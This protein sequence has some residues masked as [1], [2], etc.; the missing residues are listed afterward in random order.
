MNQANLLGIRMEAVRLGIH[1]YPSGGLERLQVSGQFGF[2]IDHSKI[3]EAWRGPKLFRSYTLA[4][5]EPN[6]DET[7]IRVNLA[8][9]GERV[10][11]GGVH[12]FMFGAWR[13]GSDR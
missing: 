2:R 7:S 4:G 5:P 6:G 9:P 13:F 3:I 1:C 11:L 10:W 8:E 12:L